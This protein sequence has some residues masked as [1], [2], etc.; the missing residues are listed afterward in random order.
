MKKITLIAAAMLAFVGSAYATDLPSKKA[1]PVKAH[2]PCDSIAIGYGQNFD[3][4]HWDNK[5]SDAYALTYT[6]C[7][8][9]FTVGA[10]YS[11]T[12]SD[13]LKQNVEAQ[14]GVKARAGAF[15]L[16]AK[17]GVGERFTQSVDF[18]YYA[19]YGTADYN[20]NES[21]T[22]NALEYRYRNS[23]DVAHDYESH[24][25]GTGVTY[26]INDTYSVNAKVFRDYDKDFGNNGDGVLVGLTIRF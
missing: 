13:E 2:A 25:L 20:L 12:N 6:K 8:G 5:T 19:V 7:L 22:I 16:G 11:A 9:P 15:V 23:F 1:P 24:R 26:K 17:V 4:N 3:S 10:A 14:A 18:P 21:W